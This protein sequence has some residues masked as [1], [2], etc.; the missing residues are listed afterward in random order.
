[1]KIPNI[2]DIL[3]NPDGVKESNPALE[4]VSMAMGRAAAAYPDQDH[5]AHIKVHLTFAMDPNYGSSPI[6]GPAYAPHLLEHLKQHITLHYLQSMRDYVGQASGDGEDVFK[7]NEERPLDKTSE[8]ALAIACQMVAQDG[9]V[10]FQPIAPA[11]QQIAQKVQQG[12]QAQMQ[13]AAEADPTAQV[14]MKT[15]MAETQRKAA[16]SQAKMQ[17]EM[18]NSQQEFQL[19]VA[20]LQQKVQE[21][22]AKYSTQTHLDSQQN[23]TTIALANIN[24][25]AKERVAQINAG[26]QMDQQQ[27]MLQHEQ[28]MAAF[29]ATK[30]AEMDIRQHGINVEQQ[31]FQQQAS[32]VASQI[33]AQK[34]AALADQQHQQQ[35]MQNDQAHQQ[36]LVQQQ[37]QAAMQPPTIPTG[38]PNGQ[39]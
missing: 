19:K 37:Q 17:A 36:V 9:Q 34:Q 11:I 23:A 38:E 6:I 3:P 29:E 31:Q 5:L 14:I 35:L 10:A 12:R 13:M 20:E 4:N 32:Q 18:Q 39:Q 25:A 15:Q 7:L 8:Q 21:L 30:A 27:S 16:E 24:N 33:D 28:D 26:V 1:M 22:Q 2:E